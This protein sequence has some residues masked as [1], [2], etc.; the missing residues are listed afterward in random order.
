MRVTQITTTRQVQR[1]DLNDRIY[2][3][4]D[5][6]FKADV[7][8]VVESHKKGKPVLLGKVEV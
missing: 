3:T 2:S 1:E 6:K 7:D 4:K 8:E 5:T